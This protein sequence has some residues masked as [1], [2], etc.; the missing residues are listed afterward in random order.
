MCAHSVRGVTVLVCVTVE[1]LQADQVPF[2][3]IGPDDSVYDAVK[4]LVDN[5]VHRLPVMD[6]PTGNVVYIL[7]HKRI[8]R[9]LSLY[10]SECSPVC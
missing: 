7:T 2:I 4:A 9:F 10:V 8:L 3:Y 6:G 1:V 5:R